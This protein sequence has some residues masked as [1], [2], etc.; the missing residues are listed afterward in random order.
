MGQLLTMVCRCLQ[1][2]T[3]EHGV[4]FASLNFTLTGVDQL[5]MV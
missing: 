4:I 2:A 3:A 5:G 1:A